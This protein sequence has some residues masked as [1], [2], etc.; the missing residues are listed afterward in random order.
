MT[1]QNRLKN[2]NTLIRTGLLFLILGSLSRWVHP[3]ANFSANFIDG[4]TGCFYGVSIAC[5]LL[6]VRLNARRGSGICATLP[7]SGSQ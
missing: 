4:A 1:F 3:S 5:M 6:G 7:R 2:P